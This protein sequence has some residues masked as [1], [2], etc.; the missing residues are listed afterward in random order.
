MVA[1]QW[2]KGNTILGCPSRL[3]GSYKHIS[4]YESVRILS[5][6]HNTLVMGT[7]GK[8]TKL[9]SLKKPSYYIAF[10]D[11]QIHTL[12]SSNH[13]YGTEYGHSYNAI[14]FRHN[15]AFNATHPDGHVSAYTGINQWHAPNEPTAWGFE[16]HKKLRPG[17]HG[18][19]AVRW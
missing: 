9:S 2:D 12:L 19:T 17:Q 18:D 6:A 7:I 4:S 8:P 10:T 3:E 1:A 14:D 5:Y 16:S 15:G 13:F 11:G